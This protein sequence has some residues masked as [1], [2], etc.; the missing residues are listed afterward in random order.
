MQEHCCN[1][2][3]V[4][5]DLQIFVNKEIENRNCILTILCVTLKASILQAKQMQSQFL[6]RTSEAFSFTVRS[7]VL[8][9][10]SQ[11]ESIRLRCCGRQI[12]EGNIDFKE[13]FRLQAQLAITFLLL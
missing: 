11:S 8:G 13:R 10:V 1:L 9:E 7:C 12:S 5:L 2:S 3:L 6:N 4:S